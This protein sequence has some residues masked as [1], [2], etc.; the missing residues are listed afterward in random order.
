MTDACRSAPPPIGYVDLPTSEAPWEAPIY[1]VPRGS[2]VILN[3]DSRYQVT[4]TFTS[5]RPPD[6]SA[7]LMLRG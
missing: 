7:I 5:R 2:H 6:D 4:T 3:P 1:G